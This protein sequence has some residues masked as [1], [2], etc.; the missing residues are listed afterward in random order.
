MKRLHARKGVLFIV[1]NVL[2]LF[3]YRRIRRLIN[4]C[5]TKKTRRSRRGRRRGLPLFLGF[6]ESARRQHN[7][8]MREN[9][10]SKHTHTLINSS[11]NERHHEHDTTRRT[12][13]LSLSLSIYL[14][15]TC[16]NTAANPE[17]GEN[18]RERVHKN[19]TTKDSLCSLSLSTTQYLSLSNV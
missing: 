11:S 6:V 1:W 7:Q 3:S 13:T 16:I 17:R 2:M 8:T 5:A 9:I 15:H 4:D 12:H 14:T 19:N 18:A 10:L